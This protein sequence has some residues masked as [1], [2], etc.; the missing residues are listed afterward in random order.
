MNP[1][2]VILAH[3]HHEQRANKCTRLKIP[4]LDQAILAAGKHGIST[5][6]ERKHSANAAVE[7]VQETRSGVR[8]VVLRQMP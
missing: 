6:D 2:P 1:I 5:D 3:L 8:R 4:N 7:R